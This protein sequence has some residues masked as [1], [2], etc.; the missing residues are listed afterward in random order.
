MMIELTRPS[1]AK[2]FVNSNRIISIE[3]STAQGVGCN[4]RT[5]VT[6]FEARESCFEVMAK[7]DDKE[8]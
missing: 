5:D 7:M 8:Q 2:V 3:P 1:G 4:V 6:H